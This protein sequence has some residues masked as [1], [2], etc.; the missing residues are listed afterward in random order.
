MRKY[1]DVDVTFWVYS[2]EK[3]EELEV[4]HNGQK[5]NKL[6]T[7]HMFVIII[8]FLYFI[9]LNHSISGKKILLMYACIDR[10]PY[11]H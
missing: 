2:I 11:F 5:K 8:G 6:R 1:P 4:G 9:T 10:V 7:V 3:K